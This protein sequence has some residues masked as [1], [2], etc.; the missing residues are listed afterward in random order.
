M[1]LTRRRIFAYLRREMGTKFR[2]V[3]R[4]MRVSCPKRNYKQEYL[5]LDNRHRAAVIVFQ[6][7]ERVLVRCR[8]QPHKT[9]SIVKN[10]GHGSWQILLDNGQYRNV[11]QRFL[12]KWLS[13]NL[14][15]DSN[16]SFFEL[17]GGYDN[18]NHQHRPQYNLRPRI[19]RPNYRT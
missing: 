8:G 2:F 7:A 17:G 15:G 11:N 5:K 18:P 6:P 10:V 9:G 13:T 1:G 12:R 14:N 4:G 19:N 16:H 3:G